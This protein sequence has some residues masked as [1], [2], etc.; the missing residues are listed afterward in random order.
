M[1]GQPDY[2]CRA[3]IINYINISSEQKIQNMEQIKFVKKI[4]F[5]LKNIKLRTIP[6]LDNVRMTLHIKI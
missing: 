4:T 2:S 1:R 3:L 6:N 5:L